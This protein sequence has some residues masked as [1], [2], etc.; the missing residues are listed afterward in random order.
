MSKNPF[1]TRMCSGCMARR[2][3]S[4]LIR[5]V[6]QSDGKTIIDKSHMLSGRGAYVCRDAEC[7]KKAQKRN[8]FSRSLKG[9]VDKEI[10]DELS[11]LVK[12]GD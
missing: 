11:E 1:P 5:I 3:K 10:Y 4:E 7:I 2:A 6:R 9:E 12:K 8:W